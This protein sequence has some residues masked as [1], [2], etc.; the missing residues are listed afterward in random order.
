MKRYKCIKEL[1]IDTWDLAGNTTG[2]Y[3]KIPVGSIYEDDG[4]DPF[5]ADKS[6]VHLTLED[7][8]IYHWIEIYPEMIEEYFKEINEG[9]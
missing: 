2:D 4:Y 6:A 3:C 9:E 1:I 8:N 5:I 7:E